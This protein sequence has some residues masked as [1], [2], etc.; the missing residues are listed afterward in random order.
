[1]TDAQIQAAL[2]IYIVVVVVICLVS[3][4]FSIVIYWRIFSRAGY[5]GAM[6]ILMLIPIAN[7]VALIILAFGEWPILRELNMLRQQVGSQPP[8]Q[9][10]PF[11]P[12]G[13]QFSPGPTYP[14]GPNYQPG[15]NP[16]YQP[17]SNPNNQSGPNYPRQ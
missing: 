8:S 5:S 1:M 14:S 10:P 7:L 9:Y 13:P 17:G 15:P 11:N 16:N 3:I 12:Q 4:V 6:S 2:M